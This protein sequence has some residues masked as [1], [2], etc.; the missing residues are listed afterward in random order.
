[1]QTGFLERSA[2]NRMNLV[3]ATEPSAHGTSAIFALDKD[4]TLWTQW[5]K[6]FDGHINYPLITRAPH[7]PGLTQATVYPAQAAN[8]LIS[9]KTDLV[10]NRPWWLVQGILTDGER[11]RENHIS[12]ICGSEIVNGEW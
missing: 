4:F 11:G 9:Q 7:A 3:V 1:M 12:V 6:P 8:R 10:A 5:E 2:E